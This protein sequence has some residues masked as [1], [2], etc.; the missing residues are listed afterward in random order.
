MQILLVADLHYALKQFDWVLSQADAFDIIVIAGD[1]L[2]ISSFV[3]LDAQVAVVDAYLEKLAARTELFVCSGNHDV[4]GLSETGEKT[5][6]WLTDHHR[7]DFITDGGSAMFGAMLISVLPWW[8]GP[9][10][11]AMIDAQ[12]EE[13]AQRPHESWLWVYHAPPSDSPVS[14]GG[15]RFF[16][17]PEH[18][19]W[20]NKWQPN[21]VLSGH[22][23]QAPFVP[24]GSWVSQI[25]NT[26]IFNMGQQPGEIPAHVILN[27]KEHAA[28]WFSIYDNQQIDLAEPG[29]APIPLAE[30]PNWVRDV[31]RRPG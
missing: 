15:N 27:T 8:D 17:D 1:L 20:I 11:R 31:G 24:D 19:S 7:A 22:V 30:L 14:W 23:H 9:A 29:S 12:F 25:G 18:R 26:R 21:Y 3:P 28:L 2:D 16:G 10:T 5:A 4:T 13:D 6:T